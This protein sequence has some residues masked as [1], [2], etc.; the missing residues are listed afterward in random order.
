MIELIPVQGEQGLVA[1]LHSGLSEL[2]LPLERDIFLL[3]VHIAGT[4]P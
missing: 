1:A 4:S 2:P 3:E